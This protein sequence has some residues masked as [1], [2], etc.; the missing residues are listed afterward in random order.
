MVTKEKKPTLKNNALFKSSISKINNTFI[1]NVENLDIVMPM[2]NLLEC[3]GNYSMTSGS[4]WNY[5]R[6]EL[7]DAN[8]NNDASGHRINKKKATSSKSFDY[9]AKIIGN[10]PDNN[11][12][13]DA[14]FADP[15]KNM[16][17]F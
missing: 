15:L 10:T 4:F 7:T 17:N 2:Y 9:K 16:S 13:L 3:S 11:S 14:E 12:R 5:Y 6:D 8:E 1:D